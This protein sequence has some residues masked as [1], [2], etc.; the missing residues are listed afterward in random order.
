MKMIGDVLGALALAD[1]RGGLEAV[2]AGHVDVEQDD[3]E[4]VVEQCAQRLAAGVGADD[5][6]AQLLE[7]RFE[8]QQ[9]LGLVVDEQDVDL[10]VGHR[11]RSETAVLRTAECRSDTCF[12]LHVG[13]RYNHTRSNDNSCSVSTGLAM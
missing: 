7:D 1:E 5:V 12:A 8:R 11:C 9:L 2:H 13:Y 6:L 3:G 10:C 4:L